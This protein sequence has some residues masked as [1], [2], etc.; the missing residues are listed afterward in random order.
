V[1]HDKLKFV[2]QNL[3]HEAL[4]SYRGAIKIRVSLKRRPL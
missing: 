4:V 2:G 3:V 1:P